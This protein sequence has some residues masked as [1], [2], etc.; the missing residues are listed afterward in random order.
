LFSYFKNCV[1]AIRERGVCASFS[2]DYTKGFFWKGVMM[3]EQA[4][5]DAGHR[6]DTRSTDATLQVAQPAGGKGRI[7]LQE[8][9]EPG[10][11]VC[12]ESGDLIRV[13]SAEVSSNAAE[14]VKKHDADPLYVE[15]I[16]NDPFVAITQARMAAANLDIEINF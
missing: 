4:L 9:T 11:Y 16:S 15:Q 3:S 5:D 12:H 2:R 14:W 13:T 10:A 6:L 1:P 8:V 7:L